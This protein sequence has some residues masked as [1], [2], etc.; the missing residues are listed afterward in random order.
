M[1]TLA[2]VGTAA[3]FLVGGG[4]LVHGVPALHH[5]IDALVALVG[6]SGAVQM[7]SEQRVMTKDFEP[8]IAEFEK[9]AASQERDLV[10]HLAALG[11]NWSLTRLDAV[12]DSPEANAACTNA[13]SSASG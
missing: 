1:K 11:R 7:L 12:N 10:E 8:R 2:V 9:L 3:M 4:I 13:A 6:G 5:P